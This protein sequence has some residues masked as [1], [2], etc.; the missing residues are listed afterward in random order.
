MGREEQG[1]A[2]EEVVQSDT[3]IRKGGEGMQDD[4]EENREANSRVK[5]TDART[6]SVVRSPLYAL[7][8][9]RKQHAMLEERSPNRVSE[10]KMTSSLIVDP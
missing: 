6:G 10:W 4:G 7:V 3:S 5:Q 8:V 9:H 2:T 1:E